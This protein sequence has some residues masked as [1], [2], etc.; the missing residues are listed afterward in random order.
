MT[1]HVARCRTAGCALGLVVSLAATPVSADEPGGNPFRMDVRKNN[2]TVATTIRGDSAGYDVEISVRQAAPGDRAGSSSIGATT[3]KQ[4]RASPSEESSQSGTAGVRSSD[5]TRP[6]LTQ[7]ADVRPANDST[8]RRPVTVTVWTPDGVGT[9]RQLREYPGPSTY[10][11]FVEGGSQGILWSPDT[12]TQALPPDVRPAGG[13]GLDPREVAL[14]I[15]ARIPLP[16]LRVRANPGLGLVA[17]PSWY[18]V[19]GYDGAGFGEARTVTIPPANP[20]DPNDR[21]TSFTVE[22]RAQG[23]RYDW[24]FGDGRG[25]TTRSLGRPY[26]AESDIQHTYQHSSLPFAA[27]FPVRVTAEYRAEF[28]VDGGAPQ[29]LP[30][31]RRTYGS[32][33]RVQEIQP[34]LVQRR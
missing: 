30:A 3:G 17:V 4:D 8:T 31:V 13:G 19:E 28:R 15:L 10:Y 21:G 32:D 12:G 18:W 24:S 20:L 29:A 9:R 1:D 33:F 7:T 25:M 34:V 6:S 11:T 23:S 2:A 16:E 5:E 27:G 22:V 26:P 14:D